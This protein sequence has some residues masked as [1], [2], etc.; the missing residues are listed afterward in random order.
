MRTS[1]GSQLASLKAILWKDL[2][3][4]WR[5]RQMLSAMIV[6]AL[7]VL[8][9]FNF[10]LELDAR[11]RINVTAGVLWVS[12]AFAGT[13]GLNRSMA[14]ENEGKA[15]D[16]LLLAPIDRSIIYF[17]KFLSNLVFMFFIEAVILPVYGLLYN[18]NLLNAGLILI[19]FLGSV[20][21]AGVG[22]LLS[23]MAMQARTRDLL[24]P[25][26]LFP[27][28][29]P[30]LVAAVR[31]SSSFLSGLAIEFIWPSLNLL[32]AYDVIMLSLAYMFFDFVIEE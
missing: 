6:F 4:E 25:V 12:F 19:V 13:L 23:S 26:L 28:L 24:L 11:E 22:T 31:A 15:L 30:A 3:I 32:I 21:Y 27:I 10:A 16:S 7:L 14:I 1:I 18:V 29:L 17:A 8:L 9:I 5:S 2:L 20:G